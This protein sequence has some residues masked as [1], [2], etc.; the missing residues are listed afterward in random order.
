LIELKLGAFQA[1]YFGQTMLYLRWLDRYERQ[2]GEE[3]P[4]G[5]IL[6]AG[7]SDE[8]VELLELEKSGVRV[9]EYLTELPAKE[10]L[11]RRL[12]DAVAQARARLERSMEE[13]DLRHL[14]LN[15][16][17]GLEVATPTGATSKKGSKTKRAPRAK[18]SPKRS[19]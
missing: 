8:R 11:K 1:A 16:E 18:A 12:H 9:A 15:A 10:V 5:L 17:L 19:K 3:P 2:P 4:I 7:K 14:S 6:C 13:T